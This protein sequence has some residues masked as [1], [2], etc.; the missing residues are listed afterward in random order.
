MEGYTG[1]TT[2]ILSTWLLQG[3]SLTLPFLIFCCFVERLKSVQ[4]H[5]AS[6]GTHGFSAERWSALHARW[7]AVTRQG[8]VGT[9]TT[10]EPWTDWIP[11]DLHGLHQVGDGCHGFSKNLHPAG[12]QVP[13]R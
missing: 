8:A 9:I 12:N 3:L 6:M 10:L 7:E 13:E 4:H 1:L 5:L 2:L 11:A